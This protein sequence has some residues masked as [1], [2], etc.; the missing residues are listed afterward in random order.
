MLANQEEQQLDWGIVTMNL[1]VESVPSVTS[2]W[3]DWIYTV[4]WAERAKEVGDLFSF[5]VS[6]LIGWRHKLLQKEG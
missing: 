2:Q 1:A 3:V 6:S 4:S 5:P